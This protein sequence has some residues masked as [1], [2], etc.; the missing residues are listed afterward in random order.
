[1]KVRNI[2]NDALLVPALARVVEPDEVVSVPPHLEG[3][4][5]PDATWEVLTDPKPARKTTTKE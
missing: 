1:M 3:N 4:A 5:W 2:T